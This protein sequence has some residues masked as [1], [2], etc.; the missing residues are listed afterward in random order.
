MKPDWK[1]APE[2]AQ[3]MAMDWD[4]SWVWYENEP[5]R[6]GEAFFPTTGKFQDAI[7]P[8]FRKSKEHRPA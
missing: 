4:G 3:W 8:D 5:I 1:D 7:R 2:W 6:E